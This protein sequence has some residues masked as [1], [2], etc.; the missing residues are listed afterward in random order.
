MA[1][2]QV[3]E[4]L[5]HP[6]SVEIPVPKFK[7][8]NWFGSSHIISEVILSLLHCFPATTRANIP[9]NDTLKAVSDPHINAPED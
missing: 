6:L 3:W 2:T 1:R 9:F 5:L 4:L 7:F 8:D